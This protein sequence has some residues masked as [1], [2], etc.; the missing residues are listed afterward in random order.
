MLAPVFLA[1]AQMGLWYVVV[2]ATVRWQS[3]F[4]SSMALA[5]ALAFSIWCGQETWQ[6]AIS[7]QRAPKGEGNEQIESD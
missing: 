3:E 6:M 4:I 1:I 5:A 2:D 7:I